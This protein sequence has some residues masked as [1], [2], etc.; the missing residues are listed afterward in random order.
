MHTQIGITSYIVLVLC[1]SVFTS[2]DFY[3]PFAS[4][5]L[6]AA[7]TGLDVMLEDAGRWKRGEK[8][9]KKKKKKKSLNVRFV[10]AM[11]W[12]HAPDPYNHVFPSLVYLTSGDY[13]PSLFSSISFA[14]LILPSIS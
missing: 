3:R 12:K 1:K 8:R 6:E 11:E 2:I 14:L 5:Q 4:V 13:F 7:S 10:L 9:K